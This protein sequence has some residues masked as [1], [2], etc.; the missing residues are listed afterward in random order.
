[1]I[2]Q[3]IGDVIRPLDTVLIHAHTWI[4]YS[5]IINGFAADELMYL[6]SGIKMEK[7]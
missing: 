4:A 5:I 6:N 1:M 3:T 2:K 7:P